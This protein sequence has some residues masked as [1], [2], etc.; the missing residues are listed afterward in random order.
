MCNWDT[1]RP[2]Y[3]LL[4]M[5]FYSKYSY[6]DK[7]WIDRTQCTQQ[8]LSVHTYVQQIRRLLTKCMQCRQRT[9]YLLI[10]VNRSIAKTSLIARWIKRYSGG[11]DFF[12]CQCIAVL[13]LLCCGKSFLSISRI[14]HSHT[15]T[16]CIRSLF[17]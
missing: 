10:S 17:W 6:D 7:H 15:W 1:E 5:D 14:Q 16:L 13:H 3:D 12:S 9:A 4:P 11:R 8:H 2:R